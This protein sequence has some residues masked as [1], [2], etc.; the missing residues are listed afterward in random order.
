V[1]GPLGD[2]LRSARPA[3]GADRPATAAA[4]HDARRS[5]WRPGAA[6]GKQR[7][8]GPR[9]GRVTFAAP[10]EKAARAAGRAAAPEFDEEMTGHAPRARAIPDGKSVE[11]ASQVDDARPASRRWSP[12]AGVG[13]EHYYRQPISCRRAAAPQVR[14]PRDTAGFFEL[15]N[16]N[17]KA[18]RAALLQTSD[19]RVQETLGVQGGRS[20]R[21][22]PARNTV[23]R[24]TVLNHLAHHAAKL[25]G[26]PEAQRRPESRGIRSHRDEPNF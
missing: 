13:G 16:R 26:L 7:L 15:S 10:R 12:T 2:L 22:T 18:A 25:T 1:A 21:P 14:S 9:V 4:F 11:A 8:A 24:R 19:R 5:R 23:Y 17:A 20:Y 6:L 3:D